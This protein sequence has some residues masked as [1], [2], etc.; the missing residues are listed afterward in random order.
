MG[1]G[2]TVA[3][4]AVGGAVGGGLVGIFGGGL[5]GAAY[6]AAVA[7]LSWWLDGALIGG[8]ATATFGAALGAVAGLTDKPASAALP[9]PGSPRQPVAAA[10]GP[11]RQQV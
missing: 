6:G 2:R 1:R 3:L 4:S 9:A 8:T 5:V 10:P 11:S 7:D